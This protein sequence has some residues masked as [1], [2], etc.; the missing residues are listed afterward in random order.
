MKDT[1][2]VLPVKEARNSRD[3]NYSSEF[4]PLRA[5]TQKSLGVK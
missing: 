3:G 4:C 1:D 5:A 2:D